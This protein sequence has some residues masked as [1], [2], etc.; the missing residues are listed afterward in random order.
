MTD[1]IGSSHTPVLADTVRFAFQIKA[2]LLKKCYYDWTSEE[3]VD[4][5]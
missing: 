1:R 2:T 4:V 3:W 5:T